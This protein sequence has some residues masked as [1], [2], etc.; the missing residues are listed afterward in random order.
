M[1]TNYDIDDF[2]RLTA[3]FTVLNTDT[4]P[5]TVAL[6]VTTPSLVTTVYTYSGGAIT[7]LSTG[8]YR[9]DLALTEPGV[10][11]YRWVGTGTAAGAEQGS[12]TVRKKNTG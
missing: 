4:D 12:L 8:M 7:R 1:A 3:T 2:A 6:T 10:W 5:T 11:Q 9:Y